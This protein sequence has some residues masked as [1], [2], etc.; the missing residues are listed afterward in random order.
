MMFCFLVMIVLCRIKVSE[1]ILAKGPKVGRLF[2]LHFSIPPIIFMACTTVNH[3]SKIWHKHLGHPKPVVLSHLINSSL[4]GNKDQSSSY[5]FFYCST[6]KLGKSKSFSFPSHST[7]AEKHFD[8]IHSDAW[9]ISPIISH[10]HYKY[11]VTFI[12]DYNKYTGIY[13]LHSK[14][15]VF[16]IFQRYVAYVETQFSSGIKVLK[17]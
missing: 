10:A 15:E 3:K 12:D 2:F 13:F 5:I 4:L 14:C 16:S 7:R 11:F 17:V 6:C 1:K 8:L 9:G